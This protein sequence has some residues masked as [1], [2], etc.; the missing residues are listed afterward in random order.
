MCGIAGFLHSDYFQKE[1]AREIITN[2]ISTISH[3][4]PERSDLWND[5]HICLAHARLSII[6]LGRSGNQP[7]ESPSGRFTILFN[8]E[9]YNHMDIREYINKKFSGYIWKSTSDAETIAHAVD[10]FDIESLL[11]KI[12]GM[13]AI[14]VWDQA[15]KKIYLCRDRFGEKPL[16]YGF[17]GRGNKKSLVFA[18]E[19]KAIFEHPLFERKLNPLSVSSYFRYGYVPEPYSIFKKINKVSAGHFFEFSLSDL[20][21]NGKG[22]NISYWSLNKVSQINP[23]ES[24]ILNKDNIQTKFE[25]LLVNAVKQQMLS[26]VPIGAFLSGG[27]DSSLV[28]S[29]MQEISSKTVKTFTI[30]FCDKNYNEASYAKLIAKHLKTDHSE[31]IL[32]AKSVLD[33]ISNLPKIYDEPFADSSQV[34]TV[35]LSRFARKSVTVALTGDGGDEILAGY[36]R[37]FLA[38]RHWKN[39]QFLPLSLREKMGQIID[40]LSEKQINSLCQHIPLVNKYKNIGEKLKKLSLILRQNTIEDFYKVLTTQWGHG[41]PLKQ[42]FVEE[43]KINY[44][45][46]K[47]CKDLDNL[48]SILWRDIHHYLPGDILTKVDR[49]S[50]ASSLETRTPFLNKDVAEFVWSLPSSL[51]IGPKGGKTLARSELEKR[52]PKT[53]FE[54][55]K[56][57]FSLPIDLWMRTN[58]RDWVEASI[59]LAE[60]DPNSVVS[61]KIIRKKWLEHLSGRYNNHSE[62]WTFLMFQ[63]WYNQYMSN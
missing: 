22:K 42:V 54:R 6:G 10:F 17:I 41:V 55:P 53:A 51:K 1:S 34:P 5:R 23:K 48:H 63:S 38:H 57:G 37:H 3:R 9:I 36:N 39:M 52:L 56:Q 19:L 45:E 21:A 50:M 62:L 18:S 20:L 32:D 15:Q 30:G 28:V 2:M 46:P 24:I 58:L 47:M 12:S 14:V 29:L 4:G 44:G 11:S 7:V 8:G 25:D 49:A 59:N 27:I 61:T 35:I 33:E 16:Y 40:I 43:H 26:E 13:F 31:L 60:K